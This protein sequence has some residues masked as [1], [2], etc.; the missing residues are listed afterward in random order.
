M[1]EEKYEVMCDIKGDKVN[2]MVITNEVNDIYKI[3]FKAQGYNTYA[4]GENFFYALL[5]LRKELELQDVKL[6]CKGCCRDVYPSPMIL[7]M[8]D[9]IKA[10]KLTMGKHALTKDIV[11]IFDPCEL[12]EYASIEEQYAYY[13]EWS[14][15]KKN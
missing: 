7:S 4:E 10:Y 11:S 6:L 1:V 9:A 14:K 13:L 15:C 12:D 8:G 2:A 3:Y 5:E